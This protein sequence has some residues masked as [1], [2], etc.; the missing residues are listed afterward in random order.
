MG[1]LPSASADDPLLESLTRF[2]VATG[3]AAGPPLGAADDFHATCSAA[4]RSRGVPESP[5]AEGSS[6]EDLRISHERP[7]QPTRFRASPRTRANQ[8]VR[9][10]THAAGG[11]GFKT[12]SPNSKSQGPLAS[13]SLRTVILSP[14]RHTGFKTCKPARPLSPPSVSKACRKRATFSS[15]SRFRTLAG[16]LVSKPV[17]NNA[18]SSAS[19]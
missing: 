11:T 13:A 15:L 10:G 2:I 16:A 14:A 5:R 12:C 18:L 6:R 19:A 4:P 7:N 3:S 8:A 9:F 1:K 17:G